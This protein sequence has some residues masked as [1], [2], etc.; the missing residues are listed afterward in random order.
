MAMKFDDVLFEQKVQVMETSAFDAV[1]GL[2]SLSGSSRCSGILTQPPPEKLLSDDKLFHLKQA[3]LDGIRVL[4]MF[5]A[6]KKNS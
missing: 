1:L 2:D 5:R 6:F 4:K 3:R